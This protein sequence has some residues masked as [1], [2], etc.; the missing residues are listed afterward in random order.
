MPTLNL[1]EYEEQSFDAIPSGRYYA[2]VFDI[3]DRETRNDGATPAGTPMI[4]VHFKITGKVGE[5]QQ[6]D[7]EYEFY[8]RRVFVN[9]V[10]PPEDHD[11]KKAKAMNGRI[12]SLFKAL[13]VEE[14]EIT[15]GEFEP[16]LE[17]YLEAPLVVQVARRERKGPDGKGTGEFE[18]PVQGFK[19]IADVD[20]TVTGGTGLI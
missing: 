7:E 5:T 2:E 3:E 19:N 6:D 4:W 15:S 11:P 16:D 20:T 13:G 12:V 9:L 17:D 8:N 1:T 10:V 18:N 14:S